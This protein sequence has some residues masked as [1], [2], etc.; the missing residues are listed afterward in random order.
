MDRALGAP[1]DGSGKGWDNC[2]RCL[3]GHTMNSRFAAPKRGNDP[4]E[5]AIRLIV[6]SAVRQWNAGS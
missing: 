4:R 5:A 3:G 6:L 1:E 2:Q